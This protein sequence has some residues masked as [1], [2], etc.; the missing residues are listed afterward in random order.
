VAQLV[1][2]L[3]WTN[4]KSGFNFQEG[5]E[6]FLFS[7]V[8]RLAPEPIKPPL[9]WVPRSVTDTHFPLLPRLRIHGAIPP[10]PI[11]SEIYFK[12]LDIR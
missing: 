3:K 2:L 12:V 11:H 8:F 10:F 9:Q 7:A 1:K 4:D 5:K 6:N